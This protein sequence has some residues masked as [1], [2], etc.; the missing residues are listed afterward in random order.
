[1]RGLIH[2]DVKPANIWIEPDGGGRAKL[3]D[4]GLA[5]EQGAAG[6]ADEPLTEAGTIIGTPAYLAPEQARGLP[7]D[8]RADLFSLGC[9]LS[10][11]C[12]G[13]PPS[14][15][16]DPLE[17]LM[18]IAT[19][20]PRRPSSVNPSVPRPLSGLITQLLAKDARKRPTTAAEVARRLAD[21][22]SG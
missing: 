12:T 22:E 16:D 14:P 15:G 4:F 6:A 8:G 18:S 3:L 1:E 19:V 21:I 7:V 5:R 10:R 11:M 9:V 2:R 17:I 20:T 13:R